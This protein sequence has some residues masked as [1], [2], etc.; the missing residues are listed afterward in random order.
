MF[1]MRAFAGLASLLLAEG[2]NFIH[3]PLH[4]IPIQDVQ[5]HTSERAAADTQSPEDDETRQDG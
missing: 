2:G 3:R 4:E 1:R 5:T